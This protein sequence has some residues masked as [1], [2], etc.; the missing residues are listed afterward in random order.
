M[1]SLDFMG[2]PV[3]ENQL[4]TETD[5]PPRLAQ[6]IKQHNDKAIQDGEE[7]IK[8]PVNAFLL[9]KGMVE[10]WNKVVKIMRFNLADDIIRN[11]TRQRNINYPTEEDLSGAV[12]GLL[13]LQDT[14]QLDTKDIADGKILN[15]QIQAVAMT[16][17]DC[18]E[19]GRTAYHTED[20]YHAIMWMQEARERVEKETVPTANLE[21]ILE[22][23]AFS[24]YKQDN[25]KRA[26]L[27]TDELYR[28]KVLTKLDE[29]TNKKL[30]TFFITVDPERDSTEKLKEFHEIFHSAYNTDPNNIRAKDN[31]RKYENLLKSKGVQHIDMRRDIPPINNSR[32]EGYMDE[33]IMLL[34]E[35]LCRQQN[36][37]VQSQL[38]CYYKM[39]RPYLRLAPFKVEIVRQNPLAALF[40][41]I[42]SDEEAR[43]IQMI[44]LPKLKR[45]ITFN[46][47]TGKSEPVAFRVAKS[48]VLKP[49]E[50]EIIKR[51]DERLELA[52]NL[53]IETSDNIAIHNYG[54]GGHYEPHLD[55]ALISAISIAMTEPEM[56]GRTIFMSNLKMSL[57]CI[58]NAALFWY[59]LMRNGEVDMRSRHAAC[60]VLTGVK[61]TANK[62]FHERGQEWRRSCGLNEFDE[63]RYVGDLGAPEPKYHLNIR[64]ET[65]KPKKMN[66]KH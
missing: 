39:D 63:E 8:H 53:E 22:H 47:L 35:A 58:K 52:T 10:D 19:I 29:K 23:L 50:H 59:S 14:Y 1:N 13:R 56:G 17:E 62:W 42:M 48:A 32:N 33:G 3:G 16:A 6:E 4:I 11:M 15:S 2:I 30:Q 51:F 55:C 37:K 46:R 60:P 7:A 45:S 44:A 57:P 38:Y 65:K 27:V 28:S 64:S 31:I 9:I 61:W 18:F 54:I 49:T 5:L 20:Y 40:Y 34:Y 12:T 26:L 24:L 43:I 36:I 25:L 66:R 21:V 41:D